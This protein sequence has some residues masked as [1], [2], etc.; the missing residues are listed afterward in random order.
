MN[1]R[2]ERTNKQ[3]HKSDQKVRELY[4]YNI[5]NVMFHKI[6]RILCINLYANKLRVR[7]QS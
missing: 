5:T 4:M 3:P 1:E 6:E 2:N 7:N